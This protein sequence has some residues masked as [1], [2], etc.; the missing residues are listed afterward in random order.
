MVVPTSSSMFSVF[1]SLTRLNVALAHLSSPNSILISS[2]KPWTILSRP[3]WSSSVHVKQMSDV[4]VAYFVSVV[5][6]IQ[7]RG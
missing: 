2:L 7:E 5:T 6:L 3:F 1:A 4:C